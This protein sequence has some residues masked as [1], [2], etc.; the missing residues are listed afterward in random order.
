M[1]HQ[2]GGSQNSACSLS[3]KPSLCHT[4]CPDK[5]AEQIASEKMGEGKHWLRNFS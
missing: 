1:D 2:Y 4:V 5:E 3:H